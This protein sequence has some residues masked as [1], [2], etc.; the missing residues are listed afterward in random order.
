M[1]LIGGALFGLIAMSTSEFLFGIDG[2]IALSQSSNYLSRE[3]L[4]ASRYIQVMATLGT[5]VFSAVVQLLFMKEPIMDTLGLKTRVK[6]IPALLSVLLVVAMQPLISYI[7]EWGLA[8]KFPAD[9]AE[10]EERLRAL[11]NQAVQAQQ[12]FLKDMS[13]MDFVFNLF[14][15]GMLA[16][17]AEELFFRRVALSLLYEATGNTHV[18]IF[19]SAILFSLAHGQFFYF[20]PLFIFG[21]V[22]GYLALWS[23]SLW[24]PVI[25]HFTNNAL[26]LVITYLGYSD[27]AENW[28]GS[29]QMLVITLSVILSALLL[30]GIKRNE[31]VE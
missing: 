28:A 3:A 5:F 17:F 1:A 31:T 21:L 11:H 6:W 13:F 9:M 15:M 30:L 4:N 19:I 7:V 26:T 12:A 14:M 22:L 24:L 20:I 27:Q 10:M 8:W 16:A 23:R 25:A 2:T 29:S 18:S